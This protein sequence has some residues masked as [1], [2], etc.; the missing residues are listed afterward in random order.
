MDYFI[1]VK[2]Y[3]RDRDKCKWSALNNLIIIKEADIK[4]IKAGKYNLGWA[5]GRGRAL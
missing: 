1:E 4:L 2:G 3:E 5:L